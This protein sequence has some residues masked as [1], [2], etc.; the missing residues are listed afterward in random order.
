MNDNLLKYTVTLKALGPVFAGSGQQIEKAEY[1]YDKHDGRVYV[2]DTFKMYKF[3][4]DNSLLEKYENAVLNSAVTSNTNTGYDRKSKDDGFN[5]LF[6]FTKQYGINRAQYSKWAKYS[7]AAGTNENFKNTQIMAFMKDPYNLPYIPGS[8]LKGALRN[9]ILNYELLLENKGSAYAHSVE[10][11]PYNRKKRKYYL[12]KIEKE[13]NTDLF[14]KLN[15]NKKYKGDAVNDIFSGLRISDSKPLSL[16]DLILCKKIDVL[17]DGKRHYVNTQRECIKPGA[18]VEFEM[19]IDKNTFG[20]DEKSLYGAIDLFYNNIKKMFLSEFQ[21]L[22]AEKGH[23]LYVGGGSGFASKTAVYALYS[24]KEKAVKTVSRILDN[25][26]SFKI[27]NGRREKMGNH[28]NDPIE[29]G[30]S[31]HIR[32]CTVYNNKLYDFGLCSVTFKPM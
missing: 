25:V 29:Y 32:K 10:T 1:I 2:I 24:D 5:L 4:K 14:H 12:S 21:R 23:L 31:P 20:Y 18:V 3:L 17:P 30:T 7:Y 15:K 26:D 6:D 8:T 13:I 19:E 27:K 11:E 16:D 28:L 22:P 9:A